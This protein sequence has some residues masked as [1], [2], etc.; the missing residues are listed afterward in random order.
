MTKTVNLSWKDC[1]IRAACVAQAI[2]RNWPHDTQLKVYGVPRGGIPA[3][4]LIS[5]AMSNRKLPVNLVMVESAD[6][7]DLIIDDI[8][9]SGATQRRFAGR[10]FFVLINK[11]VECREEE[12]PWYVF[13]WECDAPNGKTVSE[14]S[15][16]AENIR[17][18]IEYLGDD[19]NRDGLKETPNRV[20]KSYGELFSGYGKDPAEVMKCF[21]H[22][23]YNQMI[24]LKDVEFYSTCEHH[25]ITFFGKAHL[26]YLPQ[27]KVLGVSKLVMV[28]EIF[29]RRLQIQERICDQIVAALM[30]HLQP[31]GAACV[32][33]AQHL[34]MCA[35]GVGKQGSIMVTSSLAGVFQEPAVKAVFMSIIQH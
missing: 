30:E 1:Q 7:A 26:A 18:L 9:D 8:I 6:D 31:A 17:R 32:L 15:G 23:T 33:E 2:D 28:L 11:S 25:M 13:P 20:L 27:G 14:V 19:P 34:C 10:P 3:A 21:D 5:D 24:V 29:S 35:R 4:L 16:P 22:D 12:A